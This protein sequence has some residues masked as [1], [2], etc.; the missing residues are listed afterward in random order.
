[1]LP[2]IRAAVPEEAA[3]LSALAERSKRH[4]GYSDSF[5]AA[6][7]HDIV[8]SPEQIVAGPCFVAD[9]ADSPV[10][11]Y[12]L[13]ENELT[14]MFVSPD[15]IERGIGRRLMDHVATIARRRGIGTIRIVSDP[16]ATGFYKACGAVPAGTFHSQDIPGRTLPV[17]NLPV[18]PTD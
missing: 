4:W 18:S 3:T 14:R 10:G 11:F 1:M 9:V 13:E 15:H 5:I 16:N 17:L 7:R 8:V 6:T 12:L 2:V